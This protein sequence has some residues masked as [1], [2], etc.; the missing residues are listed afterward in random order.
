MTT[1][2]GLIFLTLFVCLG[3]GAVRLIAT[4][5]LHG[6]GGFGQKNTWARNALQEE[7]RALKKQGLY[8]QALE[9]YREAIL[10]KMLTF[11]W[12]ASTAR[13]AIIEIYCLQGKYDEA[14]EDMKWFVA[15]NSEKFTPWL[16]EIKALTEY[17]SSGDA[18]MVYDYISWLIET[19]KKF[20]PPAYA[21]DQ[22]ISTILRLY[23]TIGDQDAG[24]K[25]I[26]E[27]LNWTFETSDDFKH[28]KGVVQTAA[29]AAK[30]AVFDAKPDSDWRECKVLREYLLVR[31]AFEQDNRNG[32]KGCAHSP[33]GQVCMGK[34]TKVLIQS[35]YF[36]W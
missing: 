28:L 10:P 13:G 23:N 15:G 16:N 30:C 7:A 12:Q 36:P 8:E 31:E 5:K 29:Q 11:E 2:K 21:D 4:N 9:K 6:S 20:L 24:I 14:L 22:T 34:A 32:F 26:D 27:I 35:D 18:K 33:P 3:I 19:K 25:F 1:K 17:Q